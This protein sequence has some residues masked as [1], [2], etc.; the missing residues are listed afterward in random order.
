MHSKVS[1]AINNYNYSRFVGAAIE[2]ALAQTYQPVEV[3]VVDDGSTDDSWQVIESFSDRIQAIRIEN[4][5][6]GA[7]Y[8]AGFERCTGDFILFL[9]SDDLLDKQAVERCMA[10]FMADPTISKVQFQLRAI[11]GQGQETGRIFPYSMHQGD[12]TDMVSQFGHYAGPPSS[13]NIYRRSAIAAYF[14]YDTQLW[15][16]AAD[17]I[18]FLTSAFHGKVESLHTPLGSYRLH[19]NVNQRKGVLGNINKSIADSLQSESRRR[20]QALALLR[21]RSNINIQGPFLPLPWSARSRALAF[22]L[23]PEH[24]LNKRDT[25]WKIWRDQITAV[26]RWPGY[27]LPVQTA[28]IAWTGLVLL[29]PR[30]CVRHIASSNNTSFLRQLLKSTNKLSA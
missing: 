4:G 13:G 23:E 12:V 16:R 22:K 28:M 7:A 26:R 19:T 18:P 15:R 27:S 29:L 1:I 8:L 3:I 10:R 25:A 20:D 17:T 11:D 30:I 21:E 14:P 5:G 2:S 9:D 24:A 6:Q